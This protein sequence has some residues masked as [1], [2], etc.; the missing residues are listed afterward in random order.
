LEAKDIMTI[1]FLLTGFG[2]AAGILCGF[3]LAIRYLH[4]E[5]EKARQAGCESDY[6]NS[7]P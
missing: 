3:V 5:D 6:Y 1:T 4:V 2:F 7:R